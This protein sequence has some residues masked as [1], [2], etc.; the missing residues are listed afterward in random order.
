M[1]EADL[2]GEG[3]LAAWLLAFGALGAIWASRRGEFIFTRDKDSADPV[4][5]A[6]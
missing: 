6:S 2:E 3:C 4:C 1:A 5:V